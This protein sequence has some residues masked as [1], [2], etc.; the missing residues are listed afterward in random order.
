M[1]KINHKGVEGVFYTNEE[2]KI[3]QDT[4]KAQRM[5]IDTLEEELQ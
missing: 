4:I 3:F 2:L 1:E 5:L